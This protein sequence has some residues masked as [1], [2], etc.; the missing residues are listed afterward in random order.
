VSES[1]VP[2]VRTYIREQEAH[3]RTKAFD[4]EYRDL[5]RQHN[6]AF[7]ERYLLD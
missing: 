2:I 1:L 7:D 6:V 5:L 4:E 3:H